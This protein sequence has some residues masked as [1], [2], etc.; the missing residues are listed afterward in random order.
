MWS[1]PLI[2]LLGVHISYVFRFLTCLSSCP[3][4]N[5]Y[6]QSCESLLFSKLLCWWCFIT[7]KITLTRTW[8]CTPLT[9]ALGSRDRQISTSSRPACRTKWVPGQQLHLH[10]GT[11]EKKVNQT[12]KKI[13]LTKTEISISL[14]KHV[15]GSHKYFYWNTIWNLEI[16][17]Y[18]FVV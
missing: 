12:N 17:G 18:D 3:N 8:W 7:G 4:F 14:S 6:K 5:L 2:F 11:Q 16:H 15:C 9:P 1:N 10:R 13:T